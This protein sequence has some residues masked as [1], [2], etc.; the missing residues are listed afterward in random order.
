MFPKYRLHLMNDQVCGWRGAAAQTPLLAIPPNFFAI[1][2]G[3]AGLAGVWRLAGDLYHLPASIGEALSVVTAGVFLLLIVGLGIRV[4]LGSI[5]LNRLFF[6]PGLPPGLVPTLAIEMAPPVVAGNAY[7][8]LTSGRID[9]VAYVLAG[10]AV[11]MVLVQVRLVP[12][13]VKTPFAPSFWAFTFAYAAVASDAM[14]WIT[15]ELPTGGILLGSVLLAAI[16][17]L[18]GGIALR[19][20]IALRQGTFLPAS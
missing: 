19:S 3:L 13:Y 2:M 7:F 4:V 12:L 17:F 1:T 6:R 20:L 11:L 8:T 18:I 9:I 5:I 15:V 10:Y 16:T 14:R